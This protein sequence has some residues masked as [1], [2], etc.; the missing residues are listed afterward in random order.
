MKEVSMSDILEDFV[1]IA[2]FAG[3]LHK[4]P[5]TI[6]RWTTLPRGLPFVKLGSQRLIHLPTARAWI[7][8]RM[9]KPN[10]ERR[11]RKRER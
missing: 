9:R 11:R 4:H 3:D 7:M 5:R 6:H 8:S 1:D 2:R 10:P